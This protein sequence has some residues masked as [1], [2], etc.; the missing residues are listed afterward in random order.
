MFR[1]RIFIAL[2]AAAMLAGCTFEPPQSAGSVVAKAD[3]TL[4]K[5]EAGYL[6]AKAIAFLLEPFLTPAQ[7][8]RIRAAQERIENALQLARTAVTIAEQIAHL[9]EAQAATVELDAIAGSP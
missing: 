2:A 6:K 7:V 3:V 1:H 4:E 5:V 9:K 8:S